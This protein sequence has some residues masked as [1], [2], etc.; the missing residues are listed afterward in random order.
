MRHEELMDLVLQYEDLNED[1]LRIAKVHTEECPECRAMLSDIQKMESET[2]DP[3]DIPPLPVPEGSPT[4][5]GLKGDDLRQA[6]ASRGELLDRVS[7]VQR[8]KLL[9][10]NR[11]SGWALAAAACLAVLLWAPW[12][13]IESS[14]IMELR[15]TSAQV[16]RGNETT[17]LQVG[18]AFVVRFTP[19]KAGWPVVVA[20]VSD[21]NIQILHP[22]KNNSRPVVAGLPVV[23]P[24]T[25]APFTWRLEDLDTRVWVALS[26]DKSPEPTSL[27]TDL[28]NLQDQALV[29]SYLS[30]R[31]GADAVSTFQ[32]LQP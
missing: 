26:Q 20:W 8:P 4:S 24:P 27:K 15:M 7:S 17:P 32:L 31:F 11:W 23:L 6:N 19:T 30:D 25:G 28:E 18:D 13:S 10:P 3:G 1:E 22:L 29:N 21:E 5:A 12:K 14:L 9:I 16:H 2:I